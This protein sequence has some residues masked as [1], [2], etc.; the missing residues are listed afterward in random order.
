MGFE[1]EMTSC[2]EEIKK[3][4]PEKFTA[5]KDLYHSESLRINFV[6]ATLSR[7]VE[8]LGA[9]M[10]KD[11]KTVGFDAQ[12]ESP[13]QDMAISIPNQVQQFYMQVPIQYRLLYLMMFLYSH[14]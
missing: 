3:R 13:D 11:Y 8:L 1:K 4:C 14:Q 12:T 7:R 6:S 5:E 2:L 9:K 10:M